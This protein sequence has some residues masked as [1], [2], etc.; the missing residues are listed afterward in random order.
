M[1]RSIITAA[2]DK[3]VVTVKA[4]AI[5]REP[6]NMKYTYSKAKLPP[7]HGFPIGKSVIDEIILRSNTKDI[8]AMYYFHKISG[9]IVLRADY[10]GEEYHNWHGAGQT[11]I[12]VYSVP[13]GQKRAISQWLTIEVLPRL[14]SWLNDLEQAG[15]T[16]RNGRHSIAFSYNN[17]TTF[18]EEK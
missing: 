5:V 15:N 8:H 13:S 17:G 1:T 12:T 3:K 11:S 7:G 6:N 16:R 14:L 4:I 9:N 10:L 2:L 18:I